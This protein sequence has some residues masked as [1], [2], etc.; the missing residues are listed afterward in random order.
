[1][2][3]PILAAAWLLGIAAGAMWGAPPWVPCAWFVALAPAAWAHRGRG[4]GLLLLAAALAALL[5]AWRFERW[6]ETPLPDLVAYA[7]THATFEGRIDSEPDPGLT[8]V[9]YHVRAERIVGADGRWRE[10]A[11][12]A[13]VT[14]RAGARYERG[15]PVRLSG[16][17]D[18]P[19]TLEEFDY[20]AFL[21]RSDVVGAM[22]FPRVDALDGE[23]ERTLTTV[24]SGARLR[25]ERAL[26]SSLPEP[27][28][29][30]AGGIVMGRD[31]AMPDE[32]TEAFRETGL[33]HFVAVSGSNV[34]LAAALAFVLFTPLAGRSLAIVP[35]ALSIAVY[36]F[37]AGAEETVVRAAIMAAIVLAGY[38]LGRPQGGIA[39]LGAAA[40]IMTAVQPGLAVDVGFQLSV[41]STAGLMAFSPWIRHA[42]AATATR[43]GV[44]A[45]VPGMLLDVAALSLAAW[46]AALPIIWT[47]FG[48]VSLIGPLV[49]VPTVPVFAIAF[50]TSAAA[51]LAGAVWEPAGWIAGAVAWYPLGFIVWM[52]ETGASVPHAAV[53]VPRFGPEAALA[54]SLA[55]AALA[56]PAYRRLPPDRPL[57]GRIALAPVPPR[58]AHT[59]RL[60]VLGG[61]AGALAAAVAVL[62]LA[63]AGGPG[64]LEVVVLD[65]GQG[66]A[67][68][69]TTPN[70]RRVL[71]DGGPSG[72][73]LARELGATLPHWA[74]SLDAVVLTHPDA[75]HAGGLPDALARFR[76][77]AVYDTGARQETA[78]FARFAEAAGERVTLRRGDA[79]VI[80]GIRFEALWP[81][82]ERLPDEVNAGSLALIVRHGRTRI[83]LPGDIEESAQRE[84]L[85]L[86]APAADA[87]LAPHHGAGTNAD[88]FL[89][90]TGAALAVISVG[91]GNRY[92][93]PAAETLDALA[94]RA[95]LRTDLHGRVAILSDGERMRVRAERWDAAFAPAGGAR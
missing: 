6:A 13:L 73:V 12:R 17:L 35:A 18:A 89:A 78:A 38:W 25:L 16:D 64:Q 43:L 53:A 66:D 71:V 75:D 45:I 26:Q 92:D 59:V 48:Q 19:P 77:G 23:A 81:P 5:G 24:A 88:G 10:T 70:G 76:V 36:T 50:W 14:L 95:V 80:D 39:A 51:A 40:I 65:V 83:L 62:S 42:L 61:G 22:S 58:A 44:A 47:V 3:L 63:P 74:R 9:R 21:A 29:S 93:H 68:L 69:V 94:G 32:L 20:R 28:A 82:R 52:A 49:N 37:L 90:A 27:A 54:A 34:A 41:A 86:G 15:A 2:T 85:A 46:I 56:W 8:T 60:T 84:L 79:L 91:E 33:A 72:L 67:I 4:A 57:P 1:M 55:L 30:L 7:G 31:A 87:M 11:G